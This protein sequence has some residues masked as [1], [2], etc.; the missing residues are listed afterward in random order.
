MNHFENSQVNFNGVA[1]KQQ[2]K[3]PEY[4]CLPACGSLNQRLNVYAKMGENQS[5]E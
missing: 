5:S 2:D 4:G 3:F 1:R